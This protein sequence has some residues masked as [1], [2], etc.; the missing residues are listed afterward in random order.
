VQQW[1][2]IGKHSFGDGQGNLRTYLE[3]GQILDLFVDYRV[4][5]HWEGLGPEHR[6]GDGPLERHALIEAVFQW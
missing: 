5:H 1:D 2:S 6:H 3:A 4:V